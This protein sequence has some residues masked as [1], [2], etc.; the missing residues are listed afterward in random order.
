MSEHSFSLDLFYSEVEKTGKVYTIKDDKGY[1]AP[2]GADGK[3]SMPFWS[4]FSRAEKIVS[5]VAIYKGFSVEE[6]TVDDFKMWL[7]GLKKD[8][9]FVGINWSGPWGTGYDTKPEEVLERLG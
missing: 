7:K 5:T 1:P 3:R 2:K 6:M 4:T 8:G 9:M